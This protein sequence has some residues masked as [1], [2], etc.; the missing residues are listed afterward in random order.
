MS[1]Y[2][3]T[4]PQREAVQAMREQYPQLR[5][6]TAPA[7]WRVVE[8]MRADVEASRSI[9]EHIAATALI[10]APEVTPAHVEEPTAV[11][12]YGAGE[13]LIALDAESMVARG[14]T[15]H[16]T[17]ALSA[18][19]AALSKYL[20]PGSTTPLLKYDLDAWPSRPA[21]P[22]GTCAPTR[23]GRWP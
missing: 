20:Q 7:V 3:S 14:L 22:R 17:D 9:D 23:P 6:L 2:R 1:T 18:A 5:T 16:D 11:V 15:K 21:T 8:A 19:N 12:E 4:Q 13:F 10:P